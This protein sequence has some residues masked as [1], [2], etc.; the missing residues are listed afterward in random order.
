MVIIPLSILSWIAILIILVCLGVAWWRKIPISYAIIISNFLVFG[1]TLF[2]PQVIEQLGFRPVYLQPQFLPQIYTLFTSMFVH[3]GILHILG[4]MFIFFFMGIA[5]EDKIGRG[6]FLLIYLVTGVIGA[7]VFVVLPLGPPVEPTTLLV[8]ASGAIFGILGGFAYAYP[9]D[10]VVM[11]VPIGIMII[12]RIKVLYASIIFV[13]FET[14]LVILSP[15]D[16]TAHAAHF[17]GLISGIVLAAILVH[18]STEHLKKP[19]ERN[20]YGEREKPEAVNIET[21]RPLAT[22][23]ELQTMLAKIS[24]EDVPQVRD[25][26]LDHFFEKARCPVCGKP[27]QHEERRVWCYE[28]HFQAQA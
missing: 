6:K 19:S 23:P 25:L 3:A 14:L 17:G 18:G 1:I 9:W 21:L 16:G 10:E 11:P 24:K 2:S 4:N 12:M 13:A 15:G 26:W 28:G 22:T 5:F 20:R 27:L 7:L 8:G